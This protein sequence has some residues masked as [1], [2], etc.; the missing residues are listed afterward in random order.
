[1]VRTRGDVAWAAAALLTSLAAF[2][3]FAPDMPAAGLDP[4]WM[5]AMNQAVAQGLAFG[6]DIVF[7]FGPYA[8]VYTRSFHPATDALMLGGALVLAGSFA[9]SLFLLL[10]GSGWT[11]RLLLL[12]LLAGVVSSRDALFFF[13]ALAA[14]ALAWVQAQPARALDDPPPR[15]QRLALAA[16]FLSLGLLPLVKGTLLVLCGGVVVL[17]CAAFARQRRWA[18]AAIVAGTPAAALLVAWLVAGQPLDA[19]PAYAASM[20][21]T[22]SGYTEAMALQG[23][24][25]EV[26]AYLVAAFAVLWTLARR[27]RHAAAER[28]VLV[29]VFAMALFLVL[30]AGFVRHDGHAV[31]SGGFVLLA[32]LLAA[33]LAPSLRAGI[34]LVLAFVAWSVIDAQ[35]EH[36][37]FAGFTARVRDTYASALRGLERRMD[38]PD[39]LPREYAQAM[40]RLAQGAPFRGLQGAADVYSSQQ[41]ELI[42]AGNAWSPR[43]VLQSYSAYTPGLAERNRAHLAGPRAPAH[44]VFRV[45]AIDG[46][47]P[48]LEDGPSWPELLARYEPAAL[49]GDALLLQRRAAPQPAAGCGSRRSR[50][51][52]GES[53]TL[54]PGPCAEFARIHLRPSA[55]GAAA[56]L[57]YKGRP[58][59]VNLQL[60]DGSQRSF[61]LVGGMAAAGALLSPLVE[62]APEFALLYAGLDELEDKRVRAM[63]ITPMGGRRLWEP[64]YEIEFTSLQ[65]PRAPGVLRLFDTGRVA[66]PAGERRFAPAARCQV[67]IDSVNGSGAQPA[68]FAARDVLHAR[69]WLFRDAGEREVPARVFVVLTDA[70]GQRFLLEAQRTSRPDVATHFRNPALQEAGFSASA[71]L[72]ELRGAVRLG[73]AYEEGGELRVCPGIDVA[74]DIRGRLQ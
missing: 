44:V 29:L 20:V 67:S 60:Q 6:R 62:S 54:P 69:G 7:T 59:Q 63:S 18:E 12:A 51:R 71:N 31:L 28:G 8:A 9:L 37:T 27:G 58:L 61:R 66:A 3:P 41:G 36:T 25:K 53:I 64:E 42:A 68:R 5:V 13:Q 57:F 74:G 52:L 2:V 72:G 56:G 16:V 39:R 33:S 11:A 10:R 73:L 23:R 4:A 47:L 40:A 43:P 35:H 14:G 65:L 19:L 21:P 17:A 26:A 34:A 50:H 48:S 49:R 55:L 15:A 30:K 45:E 46:R 32:A 38:E 24:G 70:Q 22:V 1:M